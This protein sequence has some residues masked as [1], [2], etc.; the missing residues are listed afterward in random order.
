MSNFITNFVAKCRYIN[1]KQPDMKLTI[2]KTKTTKLLYVQKSYRDKNG[3]STTKTV[4]K[5][6]TIEDVRKRSGDQ[7]PLEWA[8]AYVKKLTQEDR[9][10]RRV[11]MPRL[12]PTVLIPKDVV[13][14]CLVGYLFLKLIYY[15]LGIDRIC[16]RLSRGRR[17]KFDLNAVLELLIYG[18]I[19]Y[20][21]SKRSTHKGAQSYLEKFDVDLQHIYHSLDVIADNDTYIQKRLY[22]N[23]LEVVKRD[24]TV[25]YY[26]CTNYFYETEQA[27]PVVVGEDGSRKAGLRQY[28][29]SKEHRPNPVVQ[30]GMFIDKT[31]FPLA[32]CINPG[33]TNEQ[34]TLIPLEKTIVEGMGIEKIVVCTDGGLSAED[35]RS[36]NSTAD[37]SFIT[38]QSLKKINDKVKD[39]ALETTGWKLLPMTQA[40]K[41]AA[42]RDKTGFYKDEDD[43]QGDE[44]EFDLTEPDTVKYYGKRTFYRE[45]WIKTEKTN[46]EQRIIVT[47]SFKY[48][49]Y[50]RM[51]RQREI[52]IAEK[53]V[54]K[55]TSGKKRSKS[56]DRFVSELFATEQGE[57]AQYKSIA[58]N[59]DAIQE[60]EKFDGF[61]AICT[62]L[63]NPAFEIFEMNHN[64]W[65]SEDAFRVLKT[66]FKAR[67]AFVWT[68]QHIKG[69]FIVCFMALLI[70]RILEKQL[71]YRHT[72]TEILS[73]LREMTMN[74]LPGE[75]YRPNYTRDDLS[76]LLHETAGF[77]TDT[78]IVTNQKIKQILNSIKKC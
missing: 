21:C 71:D 72:S 42:L 31:G 39:W 44:P 30:M 37:R 23:S 63:N 67:P 25:L 10:Q 16:E 77:R 13:Q 11:I 41:E 58:L 64:R 9:E 22:K 12:H 33:N 18:R 50:L 46:F 52:E 74:I 78:E 73:K 66:D 43:G 29:V 6:G 3:R 65:E 70:F 2:V 57:L 24:T 61:Y 17:F 60:E 55:G 53:M 59:L 15:K 36:Y 40:Q 32:M 75:G 14:S 62:D 56:P 20:P 69:H 5:L 4:E 8:K 7:D 51:L 49:T 34:T 26:D 28:G 19:I 27:D 76:D 38:V 47:F 35:N 68:D 1:I 48:R 45:K 54:K